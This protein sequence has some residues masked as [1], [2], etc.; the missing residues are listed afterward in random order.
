MTVDSSARL[1]AIYGQGL[2]LLF[3]INL[4]GKTDT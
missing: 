4:V 1:G 2:Y 3:I